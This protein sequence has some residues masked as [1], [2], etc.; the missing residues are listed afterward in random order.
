[1][2]VKQVLGLLDALEMRMTRAAVVVEP[3]GLEGVGIAYQQLDGP[4]GIGPGGHQGRLEARMRI[5]LAVNGNDR[6]A[7]GQARLEADAVPE[8][9]TDLAVARCAQAERIQVVLGA[10]R[11]VALLRRA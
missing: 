2:A 11:A 7:R 1:M 4:R 3:H 10:V 9:L 5:G 6:H 8:N